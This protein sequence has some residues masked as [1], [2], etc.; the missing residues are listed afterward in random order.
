MGITSHFAAEKTEARVQVAE[1]GF[2]VGFLA[3]LR[4]V[5]RCSI[6]LEFCCSVLPLLYSSATWF[7]NKLICDVYRVYI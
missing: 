1:P 6:C 7:F 4:L 2:Q 5:L 3:M